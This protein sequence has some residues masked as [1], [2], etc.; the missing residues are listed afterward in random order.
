MSKNAECCNNQN[1][2][3]K[4]RKFAKKTQK[5]RNIIKIVKIKVCQK[6]REISKVKIFQKKKRGKLQESKFVKK[7]MWEIQCSRYVFLGETPSSVQ[8]YEIVK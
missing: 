6:M 5:V 4:V 8:K 3:Q 2:S 1:I 7:K